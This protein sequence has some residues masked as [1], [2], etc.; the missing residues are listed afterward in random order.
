[1]DS[2]QNCKI[3][4]AK[5]KRIK[6]GLFFGGTSKERKVSLISGRN[7]A[8]YLNTKKYE[9]I[10]VEISEKGKWLVDSKTIRTIRDTANI[11]KTHLAKELIAAE[12]STTSAIDVAFLALH[13]PGGEDGTIQGMLELLGIP[14]TCSGVLASALAMDKA[15]TKKLLST[16]GVDVL[17]HVIITKEDYKKNSSQ[18]LSRIKGKVVIKPNEIGSSIGITIASDKS[19]IKKGIQNAFKFDNVLMIE[20]FLAGRE[21]TVPVLG[22]H[23][24]RVLPCIEIIPLKKSKF[25]DYEAKYDQGGSEH[26]IPA[27]LTLKQEKEVSRLAYLAHQVLGC[28]GVT[29]SDFIMDK[30]GKFYFLEINTIPGMTSTSLVPQSAAHVGI[31]FKKLLEI[32]IN[33]ALEK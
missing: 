18:I 9:I 6:I 30:N 25:Y 7:I 10:P 24:P 16:S 23:K 11:K 31:S 5:N 13:G 32:L 19:D 29:R 17:P 15:R 14:Y 4:M 27:N 2:S 33:L 8:K 21:I 3:S 1:M 26:I 28:R 20:P 12:A 22:N